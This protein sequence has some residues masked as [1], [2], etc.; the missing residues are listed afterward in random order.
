MV[1]AVAAGKFQI[2]PVAHADQALSLL[3]GLPAGER[4][5]AGEFPPGS[6]NRRI[7]DRLIELAE[8]RQSF[9][10]RSGRAD[11][12]AGRG[13]HDEDGTGKGDGDEDGDDS[14]SA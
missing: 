3:T 1:E 12:A 14:K 13:H 8:H 7:C 2:W 9:S 4:D 6:L 11:T 10:E 5:A